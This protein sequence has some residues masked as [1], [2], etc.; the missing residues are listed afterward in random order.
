MVEHF[1]LDC[2]SVRF[3]SIHPG[4]VETEMAATVS[5]VV[6]KLPKDDGKF[7]RLLSAFLVCDTEP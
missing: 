7:S 5:E 4:V 3:T 2:P 1:Q 6:H